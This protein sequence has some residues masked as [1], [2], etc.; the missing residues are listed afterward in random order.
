MKT[1][2]TRIKAARCNTTGYDDI[3]VYAA[4]RIVLHN[5]PHLKVLWMYVGEKMAQI[6]L[7]CG[8][9]D[10]GG[11]YENE[12]VVHAAGAKTPSFGS[13]GFL[14]RLIEEAGLVPVRSNAGYAVERSLQ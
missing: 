4:S 10:L 6:L 8:A 3:R 12:K 5:V 13:G 14:S 9:D 1:K 7:C 11:T 2:P